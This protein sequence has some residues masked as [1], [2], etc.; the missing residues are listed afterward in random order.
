MC[1]TRKRFSIDIQLLSYSFLIRLINRTFQL[2][3]N[4]TLVAKESTS[5]KGNFP[6][7][8]DFDLDGCIM[9][10]VDEH[11]DVHKQHTMLEFIVYTYPRTKEQI[12]YESGDWCVVDNQ[13]S[14]KRE[15]NF[16]VLQI[17]EDCI[18]VTVK[19]KDIRQETFL[20]RATGNAKK[21]N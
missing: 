21:K 7:T 8:D 17:Q 16:E 12:Q 6:V 18:L 14:P 10:I 1:L 19:P 3:S 5:F 2:H 15:D 9:N 20:Q 13:N 4:Y 11:A